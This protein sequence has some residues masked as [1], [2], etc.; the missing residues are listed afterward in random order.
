M[1]INTPAR[2]FGK[3]PLWYLATIFG[4]AIGTAIGELFLLSYE[5][6]TYWPARWIEVFFWV[7]PAG[8]AGLGIGLSQWILIRRIHKNAYFWI[9]ATTIGIIMIIGGALLILVLT[10]YYRLGNQ[11]WLFS[12]LPSWY[13]PLAIVTPIIIFTG[14]FLQW[15]ILSQVTNNHSFKEL[16]RISIGWILSTSI[17]FI[18]LALTANV[19]QARNEIVN[20]F[21]VALSTI[22]SGFILAHFTQGIVTDSL[23]KV[24][25][26]E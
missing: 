26:Y 13:V 5:L 10:S 3:K 6:V 22:P 4:F 19:I 2:I 21:S 16:L 15:L 20:L 11:T 12:N 25:V 23:S 1:P 8:G 18:L 7:F 24:A 17:L 9:L 14:P